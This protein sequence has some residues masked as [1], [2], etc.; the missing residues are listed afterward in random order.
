MRATKKIYHFNS[1]KGKE[2]PIQ[3][4]KNN[5]DYCYVNCNTFAGVLG[6]KV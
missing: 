4:F 5:I 6:I 3:T 1:Y 2:L